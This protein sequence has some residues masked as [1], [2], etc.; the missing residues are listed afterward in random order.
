MAFEDTNNDMSAAGRRKSSISAMVGREPKLSNESTNGQIMEAFNWYSS[1]TDSGDSKK[2]TLQYLKK[3][4]KGG[5]AV[6]KKLSVLKDWEFGATGWMARQLT[7]GNK[8]PETLLERFNTRMKAL[9]EKAAAVIAPLQQQAAVVVEKPISPRLY[10]QRASD[11][12]AELD[13]MI[14]DVIKNSGKDIYE[15]LSKREPSSDILTELVRY[16]TP[17]ENELKEKLKKNG[18]E[19]V[20][21]AYSRLSKKHVRSLI[22]FIDSLMGAIERLKIHKKNTRKPRAK[23]AKTA[24]QQTKKLKFKHSD[25]TYKV[26]SIPPSDIVGTLQVWVFNTK[27]RKLGVYNASDSKA[28]S[29]KGT[30][31]QEYNEASSVQKKLRKPEKV[32]Q[33][34]LTGNKVSLRKIMEGINAKSSPLNGRINADTILLRSVK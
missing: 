28:L 3:T 21:E 9:N 31:I 25:D 29:V 14:D 5:E 17:Y 13:G 1:T 15:W 24:I 20:H 32:I 33:D 12:I 10:S 11:I 27:T 22:G 4:F 16:Y 2:Y 23:K 26:T 19:Q 8:L 6:A 7:N 34:I 30:T 18:D